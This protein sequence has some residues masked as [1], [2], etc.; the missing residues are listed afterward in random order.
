[1]NTYPNY[2]A[3]RYLCYTRTMTN[4]TPS[5]EELLASIE[6][7]RIICP[8]PQFLGKFFKILKR[9]LPDDVEISSPLILGGWAG[10]NDFE[11]N[12]RFRDHL[13]I[14]RD[15]DVLDDVMKYLGT[16]SEDD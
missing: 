7:G 13:G 4:L 15:N 1:M 14:A 8:N 11:K 10:S 2:V 9:R 16:L 6:A 5:Q 12:Q 3:P